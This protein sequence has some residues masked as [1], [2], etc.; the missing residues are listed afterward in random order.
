MEQALNDGEDFE[1]LFAIPANVIASLE[2]AWK[3]RFPR[4]PIT[5]IG[6]LTAPSRAKARRSASPRGYDHFAQP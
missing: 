3:A 6:A 1:L 4:L 5:R 2:K